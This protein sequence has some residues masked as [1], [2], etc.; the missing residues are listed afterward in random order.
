[1]GDIDRNCV[2]IF[3]EM[4]IKKCLDF[5]PKRQIIEGIEDLGFLGRN[6]GGTQTLSMRKFVYRADSNLLL[7]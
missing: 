5:Y 6:N 2:L 3:D 7:V 1:M 4:T